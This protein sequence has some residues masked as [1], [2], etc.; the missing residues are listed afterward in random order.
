MIFPLA[1]GVTMIPPR[2][3]YCTPSGA[4]CT[5]S[6]AECTPS[7]AE[8]WDR[9]PVFSSRLRS[10]NSFCAQPMCAPRAEPSAPRAE[11]R[12][13]TVHRCSRLGFARRTVFERSRVHPERSQGVFHI[14]RILPVVRRYFS[15]SR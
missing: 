12:G 6:G 15:A 14:S 2:W 10:T 5:P 8:G 3:G 4:E 13:G 9:T 11:A 7:G 1:W